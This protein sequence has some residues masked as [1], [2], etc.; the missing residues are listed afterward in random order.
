MLR[1]VSV[2]KSIL[3]FLCSKK[4]FSIFEFNKVFLAIEVENLFGKLFEKCFWKL[5][6]RKIFGCNS[7][8]TLLTYGSNM[9]QE[10]YMPYHILTLHP[11]YRI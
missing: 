4:V 11:S 9:I 10:P 6:K 7:E 3:G 1:L 8:K 2:L 5:K